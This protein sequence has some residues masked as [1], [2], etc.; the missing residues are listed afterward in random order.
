MTK[1]LGTIAGRFFRDECGAGLVEF[2]LVLPLLLM[3]TFA[4]LEFGRMN[5]IR[6][7]AENAAY[8]GAR[9]AVVPGATAAEVQAAVDTIL[10]SI[11]AKNAQVT[12]SPN[13]L[14]TPSET[15]TVTVSVPSAGNAYWKLVFMANSMISAS[16]TLT[17][18]LPE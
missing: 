17:K 2:A 7:T 15:V 16:C 1:L 10:A 5:M 14:S 4:G 12:I 8:E 11:S 3:L 6:N 18:E 13:P 9:H